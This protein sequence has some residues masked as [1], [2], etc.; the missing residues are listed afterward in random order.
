MSIFSGNGRVSVRLL[1]LNVIFSLSGLAAACGDD[2]VDASAVVTQYA[3]IVRAS[4][5][6]TVAKATELDTAIRALTAAPSDATLAA[7]K[8]AWIASR[9]PYAETEAYR[10]YDGPIDDA[11]TGPEGRI[12]SW[13]LDE[14]FIDY[15]DGSTLGAGIIGSTEPITRELLIAKNE[16]G[17][18]KNIATGYHAIEFLLWGQDH[19]V[20]GPGQRPFTDYSTETNAARRKQYLETVSALLVADLT[21][22][23]DAWI[24]GAAY[25]TALLAEPST[26]SLQKILTGMGSLAGAELSGERMTVAYDNKDQEDEHSCFSD[27][28]VADLTHNAISIQN[29]WL[30]KYGTNDGPGVD[31][32][33]RARDPA[34]A[35]RLT[36]EL[37]EAVTAVGAIPQPFDQAIMGADSA[38]GRV[39]VKAAID[40]LKKAAGTI[41]EAATALGVTLNLE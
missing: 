5:G 19:D 27:N 11:E 28:T 23:R 3:A 2:A 13:P 1:R 18:E 7:A 29:V 24:E 39:K 35:D 22:V 38:P 16:L 9:I 33:V 25:P 26:S 15:V 17:G 40:A 14:V 30:G 41:V 31:D 37:A 36:S 4:Y 21:S 34:L 8:T 12:N 20:G 10:F 6:D 32:L